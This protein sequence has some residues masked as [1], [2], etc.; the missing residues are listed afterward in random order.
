MYG[1]YIDIGRIPRYDEYAA[2]GDNST[3]LMGAATDVRTVGYYVAGTSA[4]QSAVITTAGSTS[5]SGLVRREHDRAVSQYSSVQGDGTDVDT[6]AVIAPEVTNLE[7]QYYDGTEWL[8]EWDTTANAG[9]PQA[10]KI[11]LVLQQPARGSQEP[12]TYSSVDDAMSQDPDSVYSIIVR[13]PAADPIDLS[14]QGGAQSTSSG[15][16]ASGSSSGGSSTGSSGTGATGGTGS[17][18]ATGS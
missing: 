9:L 1:M 6:G 13:I 3:G 18:G 16:G 14:E 11:S 5:A 7:F 2:S 12:K 15:T 8:T 4:P 17:S 10:V